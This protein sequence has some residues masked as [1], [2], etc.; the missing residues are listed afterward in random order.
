[1]QEK[2][3]SARGSV[4]SES[5]VTAAGG[6]VTISQVN[7]SVSVTFVQRTGAAYAVS[8]LIDASEAVLIAGAIERAALCAQRQARAAE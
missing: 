2:Q 3:A 6:M 8:L 5:V 1:M 7:G 4:M